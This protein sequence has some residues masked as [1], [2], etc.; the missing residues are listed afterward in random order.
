MPYTQHDPI[1]S[2]SSLSIASLNLSYCIILIRVQYSTYILIRLGD[3]AG[4]QQSMPV[5]ALWGGASSSSPMSE[6]EELI[7][8]EKNSEHMLY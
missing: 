7:F 4:C 8:F 5:I 1:L 3:G 6:E 2:T